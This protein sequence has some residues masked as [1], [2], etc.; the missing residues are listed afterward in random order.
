MSLCEFKESHL[1]EPGFQAASLAYCLTYKNSLAITAVT[2]KVCST[3][4]TI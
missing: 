3:E 4:V 2:W 1:N